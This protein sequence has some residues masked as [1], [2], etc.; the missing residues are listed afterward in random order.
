[1]RVDVSKATTL[2]R[3]VAA[4]DESSSLAAV[5]A[6]VRDRG[7]LVAMLDSE[8]VR[9]ARLLAAHTGCPEKAFGDAGRTS[10]RE[11]RKMRQRGDTAT[12]VPAFGEALANGDV[13]GEHVDLMGSALR[14]AEGDKRK[15][16]AEKADELVEV[17]KSAT[18]DEF[19]RRLRDESRRLDDDDGI[20]KHERQ[21]S[22]SRLWHKSDAITGM[23]KIW[24]EI[25]PL[26]YAKFVARSDALVAALFAER[27]PEGCP[28]DPIQKQAFLRA[29]A[30]IADLNGEGPTMGRPE[31]I[32]VLDGSALDD[33]GEAVTDWG[34]PV[35]L[36]RSVLEDLLPEAVVTPVVVKGGF[37]VHAPGRLDVGR[38]T[39]LANAAQ[40]RVLR[41][42]YPRCAAPDCGV[43]F[44][45][46]KIHHVVWWRRGGRTDLENL[47]PVCVGHHSEL[48]RD[49][50]DVKL[51]PDRTLTI[52]MPTG[53]VMTCGPPKR[54]P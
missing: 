53:N 38:T 14:D 51:Q 1:V 44:R 16:L 39:R 43:P 32:V 11:G 34:L 4:V 12:E 20:D 3:A 45:Y 41:A 37:V 13:S 24:M 48:H 36:P 2:L 6:A 42:M 46:C 21:K 33:D 18:L 22:A 35:V 19:A 47:L 54:A 31:V 40:R 26:S 7:R 17:A 9:L 50:W 5:K 25:D 8:G 49:Q 15:K 27:V 29:M 10:Q 23:G 52:T 30:F 28:S